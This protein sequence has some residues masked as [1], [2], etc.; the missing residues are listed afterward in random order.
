M[1][2]IDN[3]N[4]NFKAGFKKCPLHKFGATYVLIK[5]YWYQ[6]DKCKAFHKINLFANSIPKKLNI[7]RDKLGIGYE[8]IS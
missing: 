2:N 7:K 5:D 3:F 4:K 8:D 6:C 1:Y